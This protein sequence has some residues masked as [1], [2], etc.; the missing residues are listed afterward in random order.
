MSSRHY[1]DNGIVWV[2]LSEFANVYHK[3]RRT[4]RNWIDD[5]FIF[6]LGYRVKKD[7]SGY[8]YIGKPAT[9]ANGSLTLQ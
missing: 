3:H 4:I 8:W 9:S 1:Y 5:G 7:A 2:P 6:K